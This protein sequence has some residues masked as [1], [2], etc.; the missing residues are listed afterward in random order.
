MSTVSNAIAK[1]TAGSQVIEQYRSIFAEVLPTHIKPETWIRVAQGALRRDEKLAAAA[2]ANPQSLVSTLMDAARRGLEPG[3]E[4]YYLVPYKG[5]V[6]G[7]VGYQGEVELMYRAGAISSVIVEVVYGKDTFQYSPGRDDRPLHDIDW[8]AEDRGPLRLVYAYAVMK[9]GATSRVVVMNRAEVMRHKAM[10]Q[11][12]DRHDSPWKKWESAMWL[13]TAAHELTKWVPT[14]A[15]YLRDQARAAGEMIRHA[16]RP[17]SAPPAPPTAA[18]PPQDRPEPVRVES[19]TG[20]VLDG[21]IVDQ[22][23]TT[24]SSGVRPLTDPQMRALH[25]SFNQLGIT[26]EVGKHGY[27]TEKL[28]RQVESLKD[29][30]TREASTVIDALKDDIKAHGGGA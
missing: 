21:T 4:Q 30:S 8:D 5:E 24:G 29:L 20:P 7:I 22:P 17:V 18:T 10:A 15:E 12:T 13:K 26:D 11:G 28:D 3:T 19:Q 25:A 2:A 6:Q 23:T 14:S 1:P 27:A 16:Q 9:D